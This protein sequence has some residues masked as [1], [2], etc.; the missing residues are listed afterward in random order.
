MTGRGIGIGIVGLA[1]LAVAGR[2]D[3]VR[4]T[5][6]VIEVPHRELTGWMAAPEPGPSLHDRAARAVDEGRAEVVET[7]V[8]T[9]RSGEPA[10]LA[11]V[12][13]V[14]FPTEFEEPMPSGSFMSVPGLG[15][16]GLP[17]RRKL[18]MITS[19][20]MRQAGVELGVLPMVLPGTGLVDMAI[21]WEWHDRPGEIVWHRHRDPW[22]RDDRRFPRFKVSEA[23][24]AATR[25]AGEFELWTVF[26][27][28]PARVPASPTRRMLFVRAEVLA[29]GGA[30]GGP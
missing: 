11:S 17:T 1:L 18:R 2:A 9:V 8:L 26:T 6:E 5:V 27:P 30:S 10:H 20:E 29:V 15:P 14:I 16:G 22:G 25:A 13:E 7:S 23:E 28:G 12:A 3:N 24:S 4:L 19:F 21:R